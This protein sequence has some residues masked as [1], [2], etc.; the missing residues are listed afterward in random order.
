MNEIAV[1]KY[2]V[3]VFAEMLGQVC[4]E[5]FYKNATEYQEISFMFT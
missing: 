3:Q 1:V 5:E 4:R 2:S